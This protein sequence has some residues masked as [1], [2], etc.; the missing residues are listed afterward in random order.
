[1]PAL[2]DRKA[3]TRHTEP[4]HIV[5]DTREQWAY[6]FDGTP[7]ADVCLS[8]GDYSV[9]GLED[10]VAVERKTLADLVGTLTQGRERFLRELERGRSLRRMALVVEADLEDILRHRYRSKAHPNSILGSLIAIS[11][12]FN[13]P[14]W[15]AGNRQ[16][17]E[18]VT[19]GILERYSKD[20]AKEPEAA[21]RPLF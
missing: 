21:D 15:F 10:E 20:R 1:M 17:G 4:L 19:L 14:V 8:V 3:T 13:V 9:E 5:R 2:G 6:D 12:R 7:A 16:G 11:S 18:R